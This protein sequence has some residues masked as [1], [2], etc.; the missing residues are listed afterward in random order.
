MKR[1]FLVLPFLTV[2]ALAVL[3]AACS[4][5]G[6]GERC[7]VR[8][9]NQGTDDCQLGLMCTPAFMLSGT[10]MSDV[11][12][13]G[14]RTTAA[15]G[16][17]CALPMNSVGADSAIPPEAASPDVATESSPADVSDAGDAG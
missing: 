15:A 12:C 6:E 11:C 17:I 13:P 2:V 1:R 16:S 10:A 4:N 5:Q 9:D 8:A 14:D 7:D 3:F